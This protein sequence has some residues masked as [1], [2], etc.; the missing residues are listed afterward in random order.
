[1][2]PSICHAASWLNQDCTH[3]ALQSCSG[4]RQFLTF[5]LKQCTWVF[6]YYQSIK[7]KYLQKISPAI[8][9]IPW[10]LD[11]SLTIAIFSETTCMLEGCRKN[12]FVFNVPKLLIAVTSQEITS[13]QHACE[14]S[15]QWKR[16]FISKSLDLV[17]DKSWRTV[18]KIWLNDITWH[19]MP[20]QCRIWIILGCKLAIGEVN[21][22]E[23]STLYSTIQNHT[24]LSDT[25]D[26][27][28]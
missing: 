7:Q 16:I 19:T 20:V 21:L 24:K 13:L 9:T 17:L 22:S 11:L 15:H 6:I 26:S 12:A 4:F 10:W 1:M 2:D 27:D 3:S 5:Y 25:K 14:I 28:L 18:L 23:C 8:K